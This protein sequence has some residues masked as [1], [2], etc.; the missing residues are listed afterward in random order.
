MKNGEFV[1]KWVIDTVKEEYQNDIALVISHTTLRIDDQEK[2]I[3]YFVPVTERGANFGQTF[4]LGEEG[5]DIWGVPWERLEKFARLEDYN[6]TCLADGEILYAR[7][8]EDEKRFLELKKQ[9]AVYLANEKVMRQKALDAYGQAK[10][11]YLET[12]FAQGSDAKMGAGYVIDYLAQA[13]AFANLKYFKKSQMEQL[14]EL[15]QMRYVPENFSEIY[16][17]ILVEKGEKRQKELCYMCI[18]LVRDFLE[19]RFDLQE[20]QQA[21]ENEFQILADWYAELSYTWLRIRYYVSENDI[22]KAYMWGCYLQMELNTVCRDFGLKKM[23]LMDSFDSENLS[24]FVDRAAELEEEMVEII[25]KNGG[26]IRCYRNIEEFL[27]EV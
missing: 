25:M 13:I 10:K 1:T 12:V 22:T 14:Q 17:K 2:A 8:P 18:G 20:K 9:Q 27:N 24:V 23:E 21:Q 16:M 5:F 11:I 4:I 6:I 7:T 15:S 26:N 19:K 3:S